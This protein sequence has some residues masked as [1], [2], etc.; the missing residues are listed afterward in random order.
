[1]SLAALESAPLGGWGWSD[2]SSAIA[3]PSFQKMNALMRWHVRTWM[4]PRAGVWL[5]QP[6]AVGPAELRAAPHLGPRIAQAG[7]PK[8]AY[9]VYESNVKGLHGPQGPNGAVHTDPDTSPRPLTA[10]SQRT[11]DRR[12]RHKCLGPISV[13]LAR[14]WRRAGGVRA[15]GPRPTR[16]RLPARATAVPHPL[17][18]RRPMMLPGLLSK[19]RMRPSRT[20]QCA[21]VVH[22]SIPP[23][24]PPSC[25]WTCMRSS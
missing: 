25:C 17:I 12:H 14:L 1:M 3:I 16:H 18:L 10:P 21:C 2:G 6:S 7:T 8:Q 19:T 11:A 15:L 22:S 9:H 13:F 4:W 5:H 23:R 20:Q 24:R